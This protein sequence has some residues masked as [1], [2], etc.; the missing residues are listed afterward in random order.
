M[1]LIDA[2]NAYQKLRDVYG[3]KT[4]DQYQPSKIETQNSSE[5]GP[6]GLYTNTKVRDFVE[7]TECHKF[8]CIYSEKQLTIQQTSNLQIAIQTWDY[9]CG[10]PIF[11]AEHSLYN[12]IFVRE[13]I[14]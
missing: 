12:I 6:S 4:S 13:K 10:A 5:R 1:T 3:K 9:T 11:P 7:C 14:S 2:L 8:R